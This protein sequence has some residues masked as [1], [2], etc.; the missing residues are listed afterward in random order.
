ML[1]GYAG[2]FSRRHKRIG[3]L[4]KNRYKSIVVE[5]EP[6]LLKLVRHLHPNPLRTNVVATLRALDRYPWSGHSALLGTIP[7]PWQATGPILAQF[8]ASRRRAIRAY[9][10]FLAAGVPQG[11]RPD[12]QGGGLLRSLGDWQA[13]TILGR[14]PEAYL[15][16][17]RILG[18]SAFVEQLRQEM[19]D[20]AALRPSR[21]ALEALVA[22]VCRHVGIPSAHLPT[23]TR[24]PAASRALA[25]IAYLWVERLGH[26][27][28]PLAASLGIRPQAVYQAIVRGRAARGDSDRLLRD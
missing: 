24:R 6:H 21:L 23:G 26:P 18:S 17:E 25:G 10:A 11:R 22:R 9:R 13:V 7:R 4:L 15:G 12:L 8:G 27:G 14:G 20:R 28:C 19:A 1:T 16:D 5:A 3:Q 2:A